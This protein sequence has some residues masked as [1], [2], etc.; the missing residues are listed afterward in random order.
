MKP[1]ATALADRIATVPDADP[2]AASAVV[3]DLIAAARAAGHDDLAASLS[4]DDRL[5]G[6]LGGALSAAPY[7]RD[8]A[9]KDAARLARLLESDPAA[10]IDGLVA[11]AATRQPDDAA[12]MRHLRRLKEDAALAIALADL[13]G[14]WD[15]AAVTGALTR[16]ADAAVGAAVG[17]L[18]AEA[19]AQGR[20]R[21]ADPSDPA[22]GSGYIVL[23]MGKHGAF[24]L[25]YSSDID[26]IV[27][28]EPRATLVDPDEVQTFFVRLTKRLVKIL[29]ERTADGYVF[30][31]D[32]RLRPDPGATPIALSAEAALIYYE[33]M[34]QNWE[35]A[36]LIKAR[37]CAGDVAAGE[38]FLKEIAPFIWRK[39][40][41]YAAIADVHSIK[42]QIHAAKGHGTVAVAGHNVKLGRGG[43]REIE[44]FV[45]TQQLIA[46][47]REPRLRGRAT[48]AML[49]MLADLGWIEEKVRTDLDAA[50]EFLRRVEHRLQMIADEQ[51]HVLPRDAAG[52]ET[53]ARLMGFADL[54]G[55]EQLLRRHLER[56]QRYYARLFEDEPELAA[57]LGNLVFTGGDDDPDTLATLARLGFRDPKAVTRTIR[58]WHFGRYP[59]MRSAKARERLTEIVPAILAAF[60]GLDNPD[61]V[62][63]D[64]DRL[65]ARLPTGVQLFSILRSNPNLLD[66]IGLVIGAA[67]R[68][69]DTIIRRPR[70][71]DALLDPAFFGTLPAEPELAARLD[72]FL[73]EARSYE[74]RLDRARIFGQEQA[75]LIGVRVL[76]G[77]IAPSDA[78]IAYATLADV[79]IR[80]L[81]A[82]AEAALVDA[83][84]R[85]AG[86]AAVVVALGK[87]GGREM[88]ATSDLDLILLYD[89]DPEAE[90]TDGRRPI[91]PSQFYARL[92]QRLVAA[93][94]ALTGEGRLYE[95]DFRLRPS[96][97]A[98]PLA[99]RIDAFEHY[100]LAEAWTWEHMALTRARPIAGDPALSRRAAAIIRTALTK[101]RDRAA[102]AADVADMRRRI[103][104]EKGTSDPFDLKQVAGG[105]IDL[106]FIAQFLMLANAAHEPGVLAP[107]TE[108]A[109]ARLASRGFLPPGEADVLK[110]A[111]ELYQA[112]TQVMRLAVEGPFRPA[113]TAK[114]V[115]ALVARAG[116]AP[117][118]ARLELELRETEAA[119]RAAFVR[120]VGPVQG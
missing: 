110:P 11:A 48:R 108:A 31:T 42:R 4:S 75:F 26:L 3:A 118:F 68:L 98:G 25:N 103:E 104:A 62:L 29:Q 105:L 84:G 43:I 39:S 38:A 6:F 45:Q 81:L 32:L 83:H 10:V 86:G 1:Q 41:D 18:V 17:H 109:L 80:A 30:R 94:S 64:F 49:A 89:H 13:A 65:L 73:A 5:A 2:D 107:T 100:Q 113:E 61:A 79:M 7:L 116:A 27:L 55:F 101:R 63:A 112:L 12:L 114:G 119:V 69:A 40:F 50:Y 14:L 35:R 21:L 99:T 74:E 53:V 8:L 22:K 90:A 82:A 72:R 93:L 23:A 16:V 59:A 71:L 88:T 24:E 120:I 34:G 77:T 92:T 58:A 96:G 102:L 54:E 66:L 51:T 91:A 56:V 36:A 20:M 117:D 37:P 78:G 15:V 44:F 115:L 106:E 9:A 46:G 67:P 87:L 97:N 28:Y 70:V 33:S 85:V 19:A 60:A 76:T 47:G 57:D 52:L 111:I 95:V